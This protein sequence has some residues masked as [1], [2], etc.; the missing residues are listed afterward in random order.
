MH[1]ITLV[2]VGIAIMALMGRLGAMFSEAL[3]QLLEGL[4]NWRG[5]PPPNHPLPA[6]DGVIVLRRAKRTALQ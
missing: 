5:G 3:E 2:Q 4:N 1:P 6:N